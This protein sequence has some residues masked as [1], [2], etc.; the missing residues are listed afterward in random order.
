MAK[1]LETRSLKAQAAAERRNRA[2]A[3]RPPFRWRTR[4]T[5]GVLVCAVTATLLPI[6]LWAALMVAAVTIRFGRR[7]MTSHR[8]QKAEPKADDAGPT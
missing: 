2:H 6:Q 7:W 4:D 1:W 3:D 8:D 5:L